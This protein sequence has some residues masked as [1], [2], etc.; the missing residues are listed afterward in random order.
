MF[1]RLVL[2]IINKINVSLLKF[3]V[4]DEYLHLLLLFSGYLSYAVFESIS[5]LYTLVETLTGMSMF[6][7]KNIIQK[8]K[9][10]SQSC[11]LFYQEIL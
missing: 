2:S 5:Y 10:I 9:D 6:A 8:P 7:I 4:N 3:A 11:L 1:E